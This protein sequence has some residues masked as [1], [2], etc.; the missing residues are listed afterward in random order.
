MSGGEREWWVLD[1]DDHEL[2]RADHAVLIDEEWWPRTAPAPLPVESC[3]EHGAYQPTSL[4]DAD[5]PTCD[6]EA[7]A[8]A[9]FETYWLT[10]EGKD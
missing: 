2:E 10:R 7:A 1:A 3:P 5:C 8:H 9:R 4:L 6:M